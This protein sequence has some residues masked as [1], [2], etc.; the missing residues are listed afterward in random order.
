MQR[1]YKLLST[2]Q[3]PRTTM[4]KV[5]TRV[6]PRAYTVRMASPCIGL[7]PFTKSPRKCIKRFLY[8]DHPVPQLACITGRVPQ[9]Y[10][11]RKKRR[12]VTASRFTRFLESY[13]L[14]TDKKRR[15]QTLYMKQIKRS[16]GSGTATR[17]STNASEM[18]SFDYFTSIDI[19]ISGKLRI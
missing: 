16:P 13:Q 3:H 6:F 19:F 7:H 5:L 4:Q 8:K 12:P 18:S 1:Q 17:R 9:L 14:E 11:R 15:P 2:C 10:R